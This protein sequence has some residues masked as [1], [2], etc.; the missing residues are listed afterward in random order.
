MV[1]FPVP[2]TVGSCVRDF[3]G[4][5]LFGALQHQIVLISMDADYLKKGFHRSENG[6]SCFQLL[7]SVFQKVQITPKMELH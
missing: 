5:H 6:E 7:H 2:N 4:A 1:D 3:W